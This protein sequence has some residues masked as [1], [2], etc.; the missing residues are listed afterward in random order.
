MELRGSINGLLQK[1]G[2]IGYA[3]AAVL[4]GVRLK[5]DSY[6]WWAKLTRMERNM[7]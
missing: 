3:R 5:I 7:N 6:R 4:Y 2:V 1:V